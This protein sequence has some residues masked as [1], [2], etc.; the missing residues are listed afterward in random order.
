MNQHAGNSF[1]LLLQISNGGDAFLHIEW[2]YAFGARKSSSR[3]LSPKRPPPAIGNPNPHD[4]NYPPA[5]LRHF[6][7]RLCEPGP[8]QPR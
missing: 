2:A 5:G 7:V 3:H 4:A 1:H 8:Q 6:R